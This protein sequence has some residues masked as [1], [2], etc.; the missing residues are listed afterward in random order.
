MPPASQD[1]APPE[2][3]DVVEHGDLGSASAKLMGNREAGDAGPF[4]KHAHVSRPK[5]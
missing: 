3:R 1:A 5:A 4:D 2:A